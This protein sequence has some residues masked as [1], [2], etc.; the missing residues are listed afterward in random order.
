MPNTVEQ[1]NK[2]SFIYDHDERV[3][4]NFD[5]DRTTVN[6]YETICDAGTFNTTTASSML[7]LFRILLVLSML[8]LFL[9]MMKLLSII[10]L[11]S[12]MNTKVFN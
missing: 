2:M 7:L 12:I 9:M 5:D 3:S 4:F 10:L 6:K 11:L 1:K 8:L